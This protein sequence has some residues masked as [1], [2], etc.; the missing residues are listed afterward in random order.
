MRIDITHP[1]CR[2]VD[3]L[4]DGKEIDLVTM[5]DEERGELERYCGPPIRVEFVDGGKR[6]AREVLRGCVEI[7]AREPYT[8]EDLE[9]VDPDWGSPAPMG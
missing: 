4:L 1:R 5:A 9:R 8:R 6:V 3:I 7:R 2:H